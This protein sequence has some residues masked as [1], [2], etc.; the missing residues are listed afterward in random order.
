MQPASQFV[1]AQQ[2]LLHRSPRVDETRPCGGQQPLLNAQMRVD[3]GSHGSM[4]AAQSGEQFHAV[5]RGQFRRRRRRGGALVGHQV[6]D[7][8]VGFVADRGNDRD[9]HGSDAPGHGFEIESSQVF[10]R[11]AASG[12]DHQVRATAH[13]LGAVQRPEQLPL[14]LEALHGDV[15]AGDAHAGKAPLHHRE[16]V[17]QGCAVPGTD[18]RHMARERRQRT[19]ALGCEQA[20]A[21][22]LALQL[23]EGR[24]QRSLAGWFDVVDDCLEVATRLVDGEPTAQHDRHAVGRREANETVAVGEHRAAQLRAVVLQAEVPMA[25]SVAAEV[26]HLAADPHELKALLHQE[27]RCRSDLADAAYAVGRQRPGRA[28]RVGLGPSPHGRLGRLYS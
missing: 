15:E 14:G 4:D 17:A 13:P 7:G 26:R 25:G 16:H 21:S 19:F 20:L 27:P 10:E 23:L 1:G 6:G 5:G 18:D 12:D 9:R 3:V 28:L 8:H 2:A 11:A 24:P 22:Q